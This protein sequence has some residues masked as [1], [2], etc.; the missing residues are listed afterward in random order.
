M[1]LIFSKRVWNIGTHFLSKL[2]EIG[3]K[4]SSDRENGDRIL[5]S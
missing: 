4:G 1:G 5:Q 3:P 2:M